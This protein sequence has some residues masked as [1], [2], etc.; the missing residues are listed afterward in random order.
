MYFIVVINIIETQ[1]ETMNHK[2]NI[3]LHLHSLTLN[4]IQRVYTE[5]SIYTRRT[6]S[7]SKI[8][9]QAVI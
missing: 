9:E 3:E 1:T 4:V 5:M 7:L 2:V 8:S 6:C